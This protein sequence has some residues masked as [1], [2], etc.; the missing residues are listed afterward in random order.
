MSR[1]AAEPQTLDEA[2]RVA[3][4]SVATAQKLTGLSAS[5]IYAGCANGSIPSV[6]VLGRI[7][8]CSA[9]FLALF[10]ADVAAEGAPACKCAGGRK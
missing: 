8:I 4:F 7:L 3:A 1:R 10:G 6:R 9:P 2:R 5:Q